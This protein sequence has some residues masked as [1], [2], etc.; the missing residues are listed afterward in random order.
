MHLDLT[1]PSMT[2]KHTPC[3]HPVILLAGIGATDLESVLEFVYRGEVSV[4]PSQLPSFLQAANCLS[5][6]GLAPPT[7]I[8]EVNL[9]LNDVFVEKSFVTLSKK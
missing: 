5:I 2:L 7:I 3:Q 1:I 4:E 8:N 9:S 6:H